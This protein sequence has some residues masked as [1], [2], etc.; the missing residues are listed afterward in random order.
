M[1]TTTLTAP[2]QFEKF[3]TELKNSYA[4]YHGYEPDSVTHSYSLDKDT[5]TVVCTITVRLTKKPELIK[6]TA[7]YSEREVLG[8]VV[9][10]S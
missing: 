5:G 1:S 6:M 9:N 2:T 7:V 4:K 3:V 8:S 10:E